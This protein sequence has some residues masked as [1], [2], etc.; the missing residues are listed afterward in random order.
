M[1]VLLIKSFSWAVAM[2]VWSVL[3]LY[4]WIPLVMLSSA[5][6]L[7]STFIAAFSGRPDFLERPEEILGT[8]ANLYSDG[9]RNLHKA[10]MGTLPEKPVGQYPLQYVFGDVFVSGFLSVLGATLVWFGLYITFNWLIER[11]IQTV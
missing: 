2:L 10:I 1:V 11:L 5:I 3:G 7:T 6:Y 8:S 9:F 4:L